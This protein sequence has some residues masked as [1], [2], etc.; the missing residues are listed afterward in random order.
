MAVLFHYF[1]YILGAG[2]VILI[3][4]CLFDGSGA[5]KHAEPRRPKQK[6]YRQ[7]DNSP[8]RQR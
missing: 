8:H 3:L 1:P 5:R 6:Y 2:L 7:D 4:L